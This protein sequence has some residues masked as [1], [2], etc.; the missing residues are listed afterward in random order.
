M[1]LPQ[2]VLWRPSRYSP[3]AS[4]G[5]VLSVIGD[6]LPDVTRVDESHRPLRDLLAEIYDTSEETEVESD[7]QQNGAGKRRQRRWQ[8]S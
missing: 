4:A 5:A 8:R 2:S 6:M 7:R 3:G 1:S